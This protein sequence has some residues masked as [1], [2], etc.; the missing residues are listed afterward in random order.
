MLGM[1]LV[2]LEELEVGFQQALK[3]TILRGKVNV[4]SSAP[5]TAS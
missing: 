2:F 1:L 3:L 5:L 4:D